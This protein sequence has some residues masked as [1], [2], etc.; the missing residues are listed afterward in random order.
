M[1]NLVPCPLVHFDPGPLSN[2]ELDLAPLLM[3][4]VD[5]G[6]DRTGV[7]A[8]VSTGVEEAESTL[9]FL[10]PDLGVMLEFRMVV[11]GVAISSIM[12]LCG[13]LSH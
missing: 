6:R 11:T 7:P 13:V 10:E 3:P 1:L 8:G 5:V 9:A 12:F 2:D 4:I